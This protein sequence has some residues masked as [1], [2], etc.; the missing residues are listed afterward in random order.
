MILTVTANSA[1]DKVIY[2]DEFIPTTD[3]R[4][5]WMVESAGGKGYDTSVVLQSLGVENLAI[6][7][8]AGFTGKQLERVLER[9]GIPM[10]LV[11]VDG[12]TRVANVIVET[13]YRRQSHVTTPGYPPSSSGSR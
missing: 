5:R 4:S 3:M 13:K 10:D 11:W 2:I 1:L 9:Y 8:M 7:I 6:G 12:E